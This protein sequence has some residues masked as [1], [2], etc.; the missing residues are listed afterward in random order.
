MAL[1]P[2]QQ[3]YMGG[4]KGLCFTYTI[5]PWRGGGGCLVIQFIA[6]LRMHA[7]ALQRQLSFLLGYILYIGE[8]NQEEKCCIKIRTE[9]RLLKRFHL[10][11]FF[12]IFFLSLIHLKESQNQ[13]QGKD[14]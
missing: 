6:A 9:S 4:Q 3:T 5:I 12:F 7:I 2:F 10:F 14:L 1:A 8:D 11:L 13:P